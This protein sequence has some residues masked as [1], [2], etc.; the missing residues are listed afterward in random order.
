MFFPKLGFDF[1][2]KKRTLNYMLRK[3]NLISYLIRE[4]IFLC[5]SPGS[6][7]EILALRLQRQ[8]AFIMTMRNVKPF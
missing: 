6:E 8:K 1:S 2:P 5:Q 3:N 4:L 7:L